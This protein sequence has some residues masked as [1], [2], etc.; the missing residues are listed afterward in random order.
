MSLTFYLALKHEISTVYCVET[1]ARGHPMMDVL[2]GRGSEV[3]LVDDA[4]VVIRERFLDIIVKILEE[5]KIELTP[6]KIKTVIQNRHLLP[7]KLIENEQ[8]F[9]MMNTSFENKEGIFYLSMKGRRTRRFGLKSWRE[10]DVKTEL[11]ESIQGFEEF[12]TNQVREIFRDIV[13]PSK[14]N[15]LNAYLAELIEDGEIE[16]VKIGVYRRKS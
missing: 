1:V 13:K 5:K 12:T 8:I 14:V 16:R 7:L 11:L 6:S 10:S 4:T 2:S 9:E 15:T 3:V